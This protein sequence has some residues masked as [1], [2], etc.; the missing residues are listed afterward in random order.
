MHELQGVIA[1][2][3]GRLLRILR[4]LLV[5]LNEVPTPMLRLGIPQ[6]KRPAGQVRLALVLT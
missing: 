6:R 2:P 5:R 1:P 3:S 4:I